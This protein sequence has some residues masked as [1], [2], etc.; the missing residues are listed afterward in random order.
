MSCALEEQSTDDSFASPQQHR[1]DH[2]K[3]F[4]EHSYAFTINAFSWGEGA[5]YTI[6]KFCSISNNL[7]IFLGGNHRPDWISTYPFPTFANTFSEAKNIKGHPATKGN[8]TIG[9]DVWIG[10]NVTIMSGVTIGDGA[11]VGAC[12]VVAK[13]VP[14]YAIVAGNPAK[15]IRYR[16][17]QETIEKLLKMAW[18]NWPIEKIR[19]N[20]HLLCSK[21]IQQFIDNNTYN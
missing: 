2:C 15:L 21:S 11:V 3:Y 6:G 10:L 9:N 13:N 20:V 18:W 8:V 16:F 12:S 17:D 14:P 1:R 7:T 4:G 5:S 19:K